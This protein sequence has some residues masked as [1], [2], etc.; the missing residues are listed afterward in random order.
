MLVL[1]RIAKNFFRQVNV[2]TCGARVGHSGCSVRSSRAR[3]GR[4]RCGARTV[5]A[6][7]S[8]QVFIILFFVLLFLVISGLI[9]I[10][11]RR[12]GHTVSIHHMESLDVLVEQVYH[13][14]LFIEKQSLFLFLVIIFVLNRLDLDIILLLVVLRPKLV[15]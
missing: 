6:L 2:G 9:L 10:V 11:V 13:L 8:S 7:Q 14:F 3:V 5:D 15:F 12:R 1:E 4:C